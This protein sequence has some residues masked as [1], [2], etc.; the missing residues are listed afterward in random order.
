MAAKIVI[1]EDNLDRQAAMRACLADRFAPLAVFFDAARETIRFL[2][3]HLA[4][5]LVI[6]LD[7]DLE[8]KPG[9]D[10]R[11]ID[12]GTGREVADYLAEKPPVCPV[13]V[14]TTNSLAGDGMV[15]VLRRASWK[16]R[17][18][19]PFNDTEWIETD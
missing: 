3:E 6:S 7:H 12:P 11:S 15:N 10:G 2:D 1:L 13:I 5:T 8:L 14:A 19:I 16:T 18:V 9:S 17:R 4:D